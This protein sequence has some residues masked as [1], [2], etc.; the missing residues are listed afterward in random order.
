M[1]FLGEMLKNSTYLADLKEQN[2]LLR[3]KMKQQKNNQENLYLQRQLYML[4]PQQ[5]MKKWVTENYEMR[6]NVVTDVDE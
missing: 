2:D 5:D 1:I 6:H 4:R 3:Q